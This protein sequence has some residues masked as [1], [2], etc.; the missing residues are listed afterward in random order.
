VVLEALA[1]GVPVV[2][3]AIGGIPEIVHDGVNGFLCPPGDVSA[4]ARG[5]QRL[6]DDRTLLATMKEAARRYAVDHLDADRMNARY[7][8]LLRNL[9]P[10]AP[11]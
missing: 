11:F 9:V 10:T 8:A 1:S 7:L 6:I 3:F 2:A 5:L 4:M